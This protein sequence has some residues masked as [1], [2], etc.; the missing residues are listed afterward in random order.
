M[1]VAEE[2]E[3]RLE[4]GKHLEAVLRREEILPLV[5]TVRRGVDERGVTDLG[6][7]RQ[8]GQIASVLR[9]EPRLRPLGG[10]AGVD[11]E[12]VEIDEPGD[13]V[14]MVAGH[15]CLRALGDRLDARH[16]IRAV[17]DQVAQAEQRV[18]PRR[19][20]REHR[21]ERFEVRVDVRQDRVPQREQA[22][23]TSGGVLCGCDRASR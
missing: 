15:D 11:V 19:R 18:G 2:A 20:V 7:Q 13:R 6:D 4:G 12:P 17:P 14:L 10:S 23:R 5:R 16:G 3:S 8:R 21:L 9:V 22:L 1:R